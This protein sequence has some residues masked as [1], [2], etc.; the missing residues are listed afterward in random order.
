MKLSLLPLFL[1]AAISS[2]VPTVFTPQDLTLQIKENITAPHGWTRLGRAPLDHSIQLRIAIFQQDF[3]G[4]EKSLYEISDPDH[5]RY[6]A[7]LSKEEVETFVAPHPASLALID[8]W[9]NS[10]GINESDL[11]RSPAKDWVSVTVPIHLAQQMLGAVRLRAFFNVVSSD[12]HISLG[13]LY[14]AAYQRRRSRSYHHLRTPSVPPRT[15]RANSAHH[16]VYEIE[17]D[18]T[19]PLS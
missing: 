6:G 3:S 5:H 16:D 14:V 2:A 17:G 10:H 4:L 1:F 13:I 18:G 15:H 12:S 19:Y 8:G 7:H 11:V 9:I